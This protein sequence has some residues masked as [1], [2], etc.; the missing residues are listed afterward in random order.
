[1]DKKLKKIINREKVKSKRGITMSILIV[2]IIVLVI[3]AVGI[4]KVSTD[5]LTK[6]TNIKMYSTLL[7]IEKI[8]DSFS[9][10]NNGDSVTTINSK[11]QK[12]VPDDKVKKYINNIDSKMSAEEKTYINT[13]YGNAYNILR[14]KQNFSDV[15]VINKGNLKDIGLSQKHLSKAISIIIQSVNTKT[16]NEQYIYYLTEPMEIKV[17]EG[18]ESKSKMIYTYNYLQKINDDGVWIG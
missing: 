2:T 11:I 8:T 9:T 4:I 16:P 13:N 6:P 18:T 1:M 15:A 12:K 3:L 14:G 17:M 7:S 10:Q 5:M